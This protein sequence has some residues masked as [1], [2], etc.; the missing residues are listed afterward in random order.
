MCPGPVK[1]YIYKL[2]LT[3]FICHHY[4]R[5]RQNLSTDRQSGQRL[6]EGMKTP[7]QGQCHR[8]THA[9]LLFW[10]MCSEMT[11]RWRAEKDEGLALI[12]DMQAGR[13][14]NAVNGVV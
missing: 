11:A 12:R 2:S 9:R 5:S 6:G 3:L 4:F 8:P 14:C 13:R 10:C 7:R 1:K